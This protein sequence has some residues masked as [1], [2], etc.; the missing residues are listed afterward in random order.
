MFKR[1]SALLLNLQQTVQPVGSRALKCFGLGT[2]SI[3]P[4]GGD[5]VFTNVVHLLGADLKF[6]HQSAGTDN[7][8]VQTLIAVRLRNRD[9]VLDAAGNRLEEF[10]NHAKRTI[11]V[12]SS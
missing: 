10:M 7:R 12:V 9:K 2:V 5:A 1:S 8:G 11:A 6:H 3:E 4:V